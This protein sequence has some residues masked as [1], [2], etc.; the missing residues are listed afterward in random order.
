VTWTPARFIPISV[1][2]GTRR[3]GGQKGK[4]TRACTTHEKKV[5]RLKVRSRRQGRVHRYHTCTGREAG[6]VP[7]SD[8]CF[9]RAPEEDP[10]EC[11][12]ADREGGP[13]GNGGG[14]VTVEEG[15][16]AVGSARIASFVD[17]PPSLPPVGLGPSPPSPLLSSSV[18]NAFPRC[19]APILS[20]N[21]SVPPFLPPSLPSS[22]PS[23]ATPPEASSLPS[24]SATPVLGPACASTPV[25]KYPLTPVLKSPLSVCS[26]LC[27]FWPP[28]R[29]PVHGLSAPLGRVE[30]LEEVDSLGPTREEEEA[31]ALYVSSPWCVDILRWCAGG[32]HS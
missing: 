25:L 32:E 22:L 17:L 9:R 24:S 15:R 18:E 19:K 4:K 26:P 10:G 23:S 16:L 11:W 20:T 3:K 14:G 13:R 12:G 21:A 8:D 29:R 5:R 27:D 2:S 7:G 28:L 30:G 6:T 31:G 1:P